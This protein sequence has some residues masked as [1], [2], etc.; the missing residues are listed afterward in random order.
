MKHLRSL[1]IASTGIRR[2]AHLCLLDRWILTPKMRLSTALWGISGLIEG[3]IE[4]K[5]K[6]EGLW[7]I[8][9]TIETNVF[10]DKFLKFRCYVKNTACFAKTRSRKVIQEETEWSKICD[11]DA[12]WFTTGGGRLNLNLFLYKMG[13]IIPH[14][15]LWGFKLPQCLAHGKWIINSNKYFYYSEF[16]F[17]GLG[18]SMKK[19]PWETILASGPALILM[20]YY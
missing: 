11:L 20:K 4:K 3:Q 8:H 14:G 17:G 10:N 5:K 18:G 15:L 2:R 19:V 1:R 13:I 6:V 16:P 7:K 12:L 9:S